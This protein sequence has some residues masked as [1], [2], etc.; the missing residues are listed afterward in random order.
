[1]IEA[2]QNTETTTEETKIGF[3][4]EKYNKVNEELTK[5]YIRTDKEW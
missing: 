4:Q 5:R 3:W 1:M 2:I